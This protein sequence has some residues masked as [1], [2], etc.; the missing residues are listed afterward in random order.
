MKA[1]EGRLGRI[2]MLR[3]EQGDQVPEAIE[4]YAA[5]KGVLAAQVFVAGHESL[6]GILACDDSGKPRLTMP[7]PGDGQTAIEWADAG[8]VI[9][10]VLGVTLRRVVDPASGRTSISSVGGTKTRVMEKA[11]PVPEETGPGT[12]PV[13]LFNA[14]FN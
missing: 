6:T 1:S 14:E 8:V 2:F 10:E 7:L 4:K 11:A 5:D 3:L 13:Y 12:I 9:Q